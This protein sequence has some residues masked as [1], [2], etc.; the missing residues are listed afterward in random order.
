MVT[1]QPVI[2]REEV[3]VEEL[4]EIH[5]KLEIELGYKGAH[6]DGLY[7]CPHHPHNGY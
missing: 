6:I 3:T 5:K 7:Y 1:N 2:E 4:N